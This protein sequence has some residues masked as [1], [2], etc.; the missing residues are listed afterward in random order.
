FCGQNPEQDLGFINCSCGNRSQPSDVCVRTRLSPLRGSIVSHLHPRLTPWALILRRFA[1][2]IADLAPPLVSGILA[3]RPAA[4]PN[5]NHVNLV[6]LLTL[7]IASDR[8]A[9]S[10]TWVPRNP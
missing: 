2:E 3:A 10:H 6:M 7:C 8:L 1:A 5:S 4:N 9:R